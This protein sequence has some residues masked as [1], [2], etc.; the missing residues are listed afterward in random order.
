MYDKITS[1]QNNFDIDWNLGTVCNYKCSYCSTNLHDGKHPFI[2]IEKAK[3]FVDMISTKYPDK[4]LNFILCGGE[5]TLWKDLPLLLRFIK[6]KNLSNNIQV[7]TNGSPSNDWWEINSIFMDSII[8]S[9]H[10]EYANKNK[11]KEVCKIVDKNKCNI[12]LTILV[13]PDKIDK[14]YELAREFI[15]HVMMKIELRIIK[16]L[17]MEPIDEY[18]DDQLKLL[19]TNNLFG[20]FK[21]DTIDHDMITNLGT[22][23]EPIAELLNQT[24]KWKGWRCYI[25]LECLKVN[26]QGN[27]YRASCRE[28]DSDKLGNINIGNYTF[29]NEP[30]ICDKEFCFCVTDIRATK[31]RVM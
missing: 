2:N 15:S 30:M 17:S 25:G 11:L 16:K 14:C 24:N 22:T 29:P 19:R 5:P 12:K 28:K 23:I 1:K 3:K 26:W 8:L 9:Y 7:I 31:E 6:E 4:I 18:T 27:I 21:Y 20:H 13:L 10:W